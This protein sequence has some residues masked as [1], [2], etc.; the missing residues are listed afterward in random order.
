MDREEALP[1]LNAK[2]DDYRKLSYDQ[3]A[4]RV[5]DEEFPEVISRSIPP[6]CLQQILHRGKQSRDHVRPEC[7]RRPVVARGRDIRRPVSSAPQSWL[8]ANA[9]EFF[10]DA[11]S[12]DLSF[13]RIGLRTD[14]STDRIMRTARLSLIFMRAFEP[15]ITQTPS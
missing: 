5:G 15:D 6:S 7:P 14:S 11:N 13:S 12:L 9:A 2:L 1:L 10:T 8:R 3:L 4:A